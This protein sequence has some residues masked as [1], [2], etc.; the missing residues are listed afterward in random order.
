MKKTTKISGIILAAVTA[1]SA[2][3]GCKSGGGSGGTIKN[4]NTLNLDVFDGGYGTEVIEKIA[5]GFKA[6]NPGTD[7]HLEAT[8]LFSEQQSKLE[9]DRYVADVIISIS[10]YTRLGVK[11]KVLDLTDLYNGYAYD[12]DGTITIK[13]KLGEA[14][15]VN[16]IAGKY[17]QVPVHSG[18]TGIAY[19]K[20]YLDAI[21]GKDS[22][23]LPVTSQELIEFCDRVSEKGGWSF[24]YTN[25]TEAEYAIWLRDIWTAQYLGYD[26]YSDYF[27]ITYTDGSGEKKK[28]QTYDEL[29][30]SM[31]DARVS[32]LTPLTKLM[33]YTGD[34]GYVP[35]SAGSMTFKQAQAYFCGYSAQED[36]KVVNGKKG[37]AF[38]V[39]GDWLWGEIEKYEKAVELD[40]R[41]MRT[42]VN[43]SVIDRCNSVKTEAQLRECIAYIDS[44]I[45]GTQ[46]TKPAYLSDED[47][48]YL[49]E[50]RRMVWSTH[51]QQ[52]ATIPV[53]CQNAEL[54]KKFLQYLASDAACAIYS[55]ALKGLVSPYDKNDKFS[56]TTTNFTSS[57]RSA[58]KKSIKVTDLVTPYTL[59][60][61]LRLFGGYYFSQNLYSGKGVDYILSECNK[62]L[63]AKW[64][65]IVSAV[66]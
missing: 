22:Y 66:G 24:V 52:I 14:A 3:A 6:E 46:G 55:S 23:S 40:V 51:G 13:E 31:K 20:V 8:K 15:D 5:E 16:E 33:K 50:A 29:A 62:L 59:Y 4:P 42:P 11:G 61:G 57:V 58:F 27:N 49:Y 36:V 30:D 60:G 48:A 21:F 54:S 28:A 9:A 56:G 12:E 41:F 44:V 39:N 18:H 35:E 45:D 34:T 19:N 47:Y 63:S 43:S 26:K 10:S 38:M 53:N 32:A 65:K 37:A 17:Y 1:V 7:Y 2:M 64:D 25:A